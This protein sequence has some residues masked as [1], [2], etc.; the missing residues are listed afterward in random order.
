MTRKQFF[1][2][3]AINFSARRQ[4]RFHD[5]HPARLPIAQAKGHG[6]DDLFARAGLLLVSGDID[7]QPVCARA[8]ADKFRSLSC[9]GEKV[10]GW[11]K[12]K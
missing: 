7:R 1:K 6:V 8:M 10:R 5:H 2:R 4:A 3:R 11:L 12:R 9:G